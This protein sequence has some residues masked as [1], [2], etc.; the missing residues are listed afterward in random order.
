MRAIS[1]FQSLP[2]PRGLSA[3]WKADRKAQNLTP[4]YISGNKDPDPFILESDFIVFFQWFQF[5][6]P[7]FNI[8]SQE[9]IT[10]VLELLGADRATAETDAQDL[11]NFNLILSQVGFFFKIFIWFYAFIV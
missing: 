4:L 10:D 8:G 1:F 7:T 6:G 9:Y 11:V 2:L 5:L 3:H